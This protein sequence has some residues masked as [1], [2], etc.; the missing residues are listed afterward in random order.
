MSKYPFFLDFGQ[1][2]AK[3]DGTGKEENGQRAGEEQPPVCIEIYR[4]GRWFPDTKQVH[5]D[6][7][8]P[9]FT[10]PLYYRECDP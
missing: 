10:R 1:I 2:A 4:L 3:A 6:T 9:G 8:R 7:L 5:G